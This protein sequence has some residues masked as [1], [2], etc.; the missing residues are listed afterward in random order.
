MKRL[1]RSEVDFASFE[2]KFVRSKRPVEKMSG[3]EV[4]VA[5]VLP[6]STGE[7]LCNSPKVAHGGETREENVTLGL[8]DGESSS[9]ESDDEEKDE[10]FQSKGKEVMEISFDGS[11]ARKINVM[12]KNPNFN[13]PRDV[14]SIR[15]LSY[16]VFKA[17]E[18]VRKHFDWEEVE[19]ERGQ[20]R[21]RKGVTVVSNPC[22]RG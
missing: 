16:A 10:T 20:E 7:E 9:E 21:E 4:A 11:D 6:G 5:D 22:W 12:S 1:N 3:E 17:Y 8:P 14:P 19:K 18:S 2:K 15:P 13:K